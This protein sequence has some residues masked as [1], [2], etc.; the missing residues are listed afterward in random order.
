MYIQLK[1]TLA[2]ADAARLRLSSSQRC[3][4]SKACN[5]DTAQPLGKLQVGSL[6]D[7]H[8]FFNTSCVLL[9]AYSQGSPDS[10]FPVIIQFFG[11]PP[12]SCYI[13]NVH[14]FLKQAKQMESILKLQVWNSTDIKCTKP[15]VHSLI[16]LVHLRP[17]H[18]CT[19]MQ[20]LTHTYIF[21]F[22]HVYQVQN[23]WS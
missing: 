14:D 5:Q 4:A 10:S 9:F 22:Q 23:T 6:S 3:A 18:S 17:A 12:A 2:L 21:F 16:L 11:H 13:E 1:I 7:F 20:A 19:S 8:T 15:G